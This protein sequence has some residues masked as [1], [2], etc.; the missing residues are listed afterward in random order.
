M[1][2]LVARC[3]VCVDSLLSMIGGCGCWIGC[4]CCIMFVNETKWFLKVG[5][6]LFYSVFIV[7]M[8]SLV[9]A[10]CF[11][12]VVPSVFSSVLM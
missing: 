11:C 3:S 6:G 4:G 10:L 1:F 8:C 12:S 7:A 9:R 5:S 2:V